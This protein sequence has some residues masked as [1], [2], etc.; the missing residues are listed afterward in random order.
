MELFEINPFVRFAHKRSYIVDYD[1]FVMAYDYRLFYVSRGAIE[2]IFEDTAVT[3]TENYM[4]VIPP[5]TKYILKKLDDCEYIVINFDMDF[6]MFDHKNPQHPRSVGEFCKK[7]VLSVNLYNNVPIFLSGNENAKKMLSEICA[8]YT[9]KSFYSI[10][11]SSAFLK[12]VIVESIIHTKLD[13]TPKIVND[14]KKY[15]DENYDKAITNNGLGDKFL[16]HPNHLNRLFKTHTQRSIREFI[17]DVRL[18]KAVSMLN[19][20]NLSI[21]QIGEACGFSSSA[22]FIKKFKE[23]YGISPLKFRNQKFNKV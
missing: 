18:T 3:L 17:I 21:T 8:E 15:I 6:A 16:Y 12:S 7:A 22:Y 14:I 9:K 11:K 5:A 19:K 4:T 2:I 13:K 23:K 1:D 20:T 10:E